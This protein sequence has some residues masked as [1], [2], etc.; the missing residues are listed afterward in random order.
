MPFVKLDT[1]ILNSTLWFERMCREI[2]LTALLMAEPREFAEAQEQI[3]IRSMKKTGWKVPPGWYGFVPAASVGIIRRAMIDDQEA[4]LDAM[5]QLGSPEAGS[6]TAD[7]DGRRLV[8][9]DGGFI[10]LNYFKY[11][12]RDYTAA[13]R[14]AR[15]RARK[16]AG[17][18]K[19]QQSSTSSVSS[20]RD[21]D[22]VT[23][24]GGEQSRDVTQA[25][26]E[27][28]AKITKTLGKSSRASATSVSDDEWLR[29]LA[30]DKTYNGLDVVREHGKML[31][32]CKANNKTA[33]R[34]RFINWLNRAE[35]PMSRTAPSAHDDDRIEAEMN[36]SRRRLQEYREKKASKL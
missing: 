22:G 12:D 23:R 5:E 18:S 36:A 32:W 25:E 21:V 27:A 13:E 6:R 3:E 7:F 19:R 15:Y 33:S 28:E 29:S 4:G 20:R 26:A 2:F 9:V 24:D 8:R 17:I 34:R 31:N 16:K 30:Q 1:N 11:R 14:Q 10:V 35:R